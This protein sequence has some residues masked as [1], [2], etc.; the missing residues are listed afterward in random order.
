MITLDKVSKQ[1]KNKLAVS[2]VS[3]RLNENQI[4]GLVGP[5]GAGKSTILR[6]LSDI[7]SPSDGKVIRDKDILTG[8]VFDYNGLYPQLT[9]E[10]NLLFY[11]KINKKGEASDVIVVEDALRSLGLLEVKNEKVKGFSKGMLRK[12]AIARAVIINPNVLILDEPFDGLDIESHSY[13]VDF[14]K[15]WACNEKRAVIFSTHNMADIE[16]ICTNL[17][18]ISAGRVK[19]DSE[20][21]KLKNDTYKGIKVIFEQHYSEEELKT[22]LQNINICDYTYN[23]L[24]LICNC[25]MQYTNLLINEFVKNRYALKAFFPIYNSLEDVYL[26]LIGEKN[27]KFNEERIKGWI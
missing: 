18:I 7:N 5:N 15:K 8:V 13:L 23:D 26:S 25:E 24:E 16:N 17:V 1:Y 6:I 14:L 11:Y 10:E 2:E 12:L 20:M 21:E 22:I 4:L 19:I 3:F 9:A 27:V